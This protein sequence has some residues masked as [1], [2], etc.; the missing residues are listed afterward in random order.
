MLLWHWT[1][2]LITS[3]VTAPILAGLNYWVMNRDP[4]PQEYR[5]NLWEKWVCLI[6]GLCA[7]F[8]LG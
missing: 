6:G 8:R 4:V 3:F 5:P 1:G 7:E 2:G